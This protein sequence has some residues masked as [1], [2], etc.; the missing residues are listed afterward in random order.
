MFDVALCSKQVGAM[1]LQLHKNTS[2]FALSLIHISNFT[3]AIDSQ[4]EKSIILW[5]TRVSPID[6]Q[7]AITKVIAIENVNGLLCLLRVLEDHITEAPKGPQSYATLHANSV[8]VQIGWIDWPLAL[9]DIAPAS[10]SH[11][12][13]TART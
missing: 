1:D 9:G 6:S 7:F 11:A 8:V 4:N 12:Q 2:N 3:Q 13:N 5:R 10:Y